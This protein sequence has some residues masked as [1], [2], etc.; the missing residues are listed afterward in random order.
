MLVIPPDIEIFASVD[1]PLTFNVPFTSSLW[2]GDVVPI[3]TLPPSPIKNLSANVAPSIAEISVEYAIWEAKPIQRPCLPYVD[4]ILHI[5]I[6]DPASHVV[7][8]TTPYVGLP[9]GVII[10]L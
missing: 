5:P 3:P 2:V 4:C 7:Y 9:F 6:F 10:S 8:L 1:V